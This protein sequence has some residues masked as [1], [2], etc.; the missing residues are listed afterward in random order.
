MVLEKRTT[1]NLYDQNIYGVFQ[2]TRIHG[3]AAIP[4]PVLAKSVP[5]ELPFAVHAE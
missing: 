3:R 1:E 5:S 2:M 4:K